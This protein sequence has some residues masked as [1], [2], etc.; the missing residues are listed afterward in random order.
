MSKWPSHGNSRV[1]VRYVEG[2]ATGVYKPGAEASV[3]VPLLADGQVHEQRLL[4]ELKRVGIV[5]RSVREIGTV[6]QAAS[7]CSPQMMPPEAGFQPGASY[8]LVISLDD[9]NALVGGDAEVDVQDDRTDDEIEAE[10]MELADMLEEAIEAG[11]YVVSNTLEDHPANSAWI[12]VKR[13]N[14]VKDLIAEY[15]DAIE[16]AS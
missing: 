11:T 10:L 8:F 15:L 2:I 14:D 5:S 13:E 9:M 6:F 7:D 12:R 1:P 4:E 16:D 3:L